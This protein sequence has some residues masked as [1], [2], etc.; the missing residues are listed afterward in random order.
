MNTP[1]SLSV[2]RTGERLDTFLVHYASGHPHLKLPTSRADFSRAIKSG[3]ITINHKPA[4]PSTPL[5]AG[6]TVQ[7]S[8]F[9]VQQSPL[10]PHHALS[11]P[12]LFENKDFIIINK[13]AGIQTHPSATETSTTVVNWLIANFPEISS[14]GEDPLRPGIVHRLDKNT[15]GLLIIAKTQATFQE[16][17]MLFQHRKIAKTYLALVYGHIQPQEGII[18]KPIARS[19]TLAKQATGD[20][21][22]RGT[23]RPARTEYTVITRYSDFDMIE[24]HPKTGRTHQIRVHLASIGHPIAGDSLYTPKSI[25]R[26]DFPFFKRHLLHASRLQFEL[27]GE[28]YSFESPLPQDFQESVLAIATS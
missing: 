13:P 18:D 27:F 2:K 8:F 7:L 16:L 24:A 23:L 17:K 20:K 10:L 5:K 15:S 9:P 25:K 4:K 11:I 21:H 3:N 12:I 22:T 14:I 6:D 26:G 1:L 28:K 19:R